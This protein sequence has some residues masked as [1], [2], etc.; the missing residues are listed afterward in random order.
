MADV[1]DLRQKILDRGVE[2]V[3]AAAADVRDETADAAPHGETG[4]LR[5]S[6]RVVSVTPGEVVTAELESDTPYAAAVAEGSRP[7]EI[8]ASSKRALRFVSGGRVVIVR[9]VRHPGTKPNP[10]WWSAEAIGR[11]FRDALERHSS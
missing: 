10:A 7:H 3:A 2:L 1:S 4:R 9:S 5:E 8:R 11:R 6:H